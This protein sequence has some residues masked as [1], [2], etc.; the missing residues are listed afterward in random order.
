MAS[1]PF[2]R[3]Y[4][5]RPLSTLFLCLPGIALCSWYAFSA[6]SRFDS[7]R[8]LADDKVTLTVEDF[9][10]SLYDVL[11]QDLRRIFI[12]S[13]PDPP[14]LEVFAF[15]IRSEELGALFRGSELEDQR[16]YVAAKLER[17]GALQPVEIRLR[18]QRHWNLLGKQKT[19]KV[20]LPKGELIHGHRVFNLINGPSPMVVDEQLIL[21]LSH[22]KGVLTPMSQFVRVRMNATDLGVYHYETQ[23]DESLLR[24]NRRMPGSIYSGDL[25]PSAETEELWND[26][27]RWKKV[28]WRIDKEKEDLSD[29]KRFLHNIKQSTV[30]DFARFTEEEIDL[31]AFATFDA[32]DVAFGGDQH[33]FRENHKYYRDP[34]RGRWEPIAWNF[35]GFQN[36]PLFNLV[37]NPVL[38]R[39]KLVPEYLSLRNA[40]LYRF[41]V[42]KGSVNAVRNRGTAILKKLAPELATD[43][44]WDAYRLLPRVDEFHREMVRPMNLKR[45][46]LVFE[47]EMETYSKRHAFL[48]NKLEKNPLWLD[49]RNL[50][51][52]SPFSFNL[53]ID[54]Q[55]GVKLKGLTVSWSPECRNVRWRVIKA[56]KPVTPIS[57]NNWVELDQPTDLYPAIAFVARENPNARRGEIRSEI[58]PIAYP[59]LLD[60]TCTPTAIEAT[61]IHMATGSRVRSRPAEESVFS[62][63]PRRS[64]RPN[65]VP[66]MVEGEVSAHPWSLTRPEVKT[67][68]LGP[69]QTDIDKT[70]VFQEHQSVEIAPGTRFRMAPSASLIFKGRVRFSG[71]RDQP[72]VLEG[73]GAD[74][75]GGIA[76]QGP[77]TAGSVL[78]HMIVR[79]G[80]RPSGERIPYPGMVNIHDTRGIVI[81]HCRFSDNQVS[82]DV[83]HVAYVKKLLVEDCTIENGFADAWDLEFVQADLTRLQVSGVGDDAVDLMG[84][85]VDISDSLLSS[86]RGNGISSG[87]ESRATVRNTLVADSRVGVLVKNAS[88]AELFSTLLF[89]N[90]IGVRVY[91]REV[92]FEG[93]S[94]VEADVLFIVDSR[95][96]IKRSDRSRDLL[97]VG[98][99]QRGFPQKGVLDN[100][101]ENV[102]GIP[103]WDQLSD[104]LQSQIVSTNH[105]GAHEN[106]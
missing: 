73:A 12:A 33:D 80:S 49:A 38:L 65:Q 95:R 104:W 45:V 35:R 9:Q 43:P 77:A 72:I 13:P 7:Y 97:D 39:L 86:C 37:E 79:G 20:Q 89:R 81:K 78:E 19:V 58:V 6:Y 11:Q 32:I 62:R 26:L 30:E 56:G 15:H 24:F 85:D 82:D 74:H 17:D 106:Q 67:V 50:G 36:D 59:F 61:A 70:K 102:I 98:R 48:V 4:L 64:L 44:Y 55:T 25:P 88:H 60:S 2:R 83:V 99:I 94:R 75:W 22:S 100:L 87:E 53:I 54:G 92:R 8:R 40:I 63:L 68:R 91:Q 52:S 76:L 14:T 1:S 105:R 21:D 66:Q 41:L 28:A 69:G 84:S 3:I 101:R 29:L 96:A 51:D 34:Y 71:T 46:S 10:L 18:G 31:D 23:P 47:S 57:S 42:K 5:V 93:N 16:P 90:Q 103:L 27:T